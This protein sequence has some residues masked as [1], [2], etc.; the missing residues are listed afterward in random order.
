MV[1]WD[2]LNQLARRMR[3]GEPYPKLFE[4][5]FHATPEAMD[6]RLM[7]FWKTGY[8]RV[9]RFPQGL[10]RSVAPGRSTVASSGDVAFALGLLHVTEG[11]E[12]EANATFAQ[13]VAQ[14]P[15]DARGYEGLAAVAEMK[16]DLSLM[17]QRFCDAAAHGSDYYLAQYY[18]QLETVQS[19]SGREAVADGT[20]ATLARKAVDAMKSIARTKPSLLVAYQSMAGLMGAVDNANTDDEAFLKSAR[21]NFPGDAMLEAGQAALELKAHRYATAK[22]RIDRIRAGEFAQGDVEAAA[23]FARRLDLRLAAIVNLQWAGKFFANGR[24][25]EARELLDHLQGAPLLPEERKNFETLRKAITTEET[26]AKARDALARRD[27]DLAVSCLGNLKV[28]ELSPK[29]VETLNQLKS[30]L[31]AARK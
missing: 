13:M 10:T 29:A 19:L 6:Q 16:G 12:V 14:S 8:N 4:E 23:R 3:A 30:E 22:K 1:G 28:A 21:E 24:I 7:K 27:F 15:A 9:F 17:A 5:I 31:S 20:D 2:K 25:P 26:F 11:H 18:A